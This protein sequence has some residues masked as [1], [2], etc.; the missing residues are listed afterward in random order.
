MPD[1]V[2]AVAH[3]CLRH[4]I[5]LSYEAQAEGVTKDQVLD[6]LLKLVAVA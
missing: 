1:D 3:V 6:E 4:R 2:Q 5:M